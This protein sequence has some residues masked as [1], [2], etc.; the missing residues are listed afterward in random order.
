MLTSLTKLQ[1]GN[2]IIEKIENLD[3]LVNLRELDL[4][5]N[6]IKVIENL[7]VSHTSF[8]STVVKKDYA[9]KKVYRSEKVIN[10]SFS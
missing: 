8:E 4:S 3:S 1:L 7:D 5:F 2:N 6:H 10:S 9:L